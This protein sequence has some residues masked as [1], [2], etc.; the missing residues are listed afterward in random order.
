MVG[1]TAPTSHAAALAKVGDAREAETTTG[2][3]QVT[4]RESAAGDAE[5][6]NPVPWYPAQRMY[7]APPLAVRQLTERLCA[8]AIAS[9]TDT[10]VVGD[11]TAQK[12]GAK[13]GTA[14]ST[15]SALQKAEATA[16][17]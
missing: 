12:E 17:K 5:G 4:A 16:E 15:N 3:V 14:N 9:A 2:S 8:E 1:D 13:M 7:E 11:L 10:A 6:V